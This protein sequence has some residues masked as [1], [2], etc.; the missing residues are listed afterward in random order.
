MDNMGNLGFLGQFYL[1]NS[2]VALSLAFKKNLQNKK[3]PTYP[4]Y[5]QD[6]T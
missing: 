3:F 6:V 5:F 4:I 2:N 1:A